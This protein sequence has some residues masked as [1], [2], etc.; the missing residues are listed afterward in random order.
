MQI[1][2]GIVHKIVRV[3]MDSISILVKTSYLM[4]NDLVYLAALPSFI[5]FHLSLSLSLSL[6]L[7]SVLL[8]VSA[9]ECIEAGT[10]ID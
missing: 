10:A 8:A 6:S 9:H 4:S 7:T 5:S 2:Q 3:Q 1:A